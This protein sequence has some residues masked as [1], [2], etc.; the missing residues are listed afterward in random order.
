MEDGRLPEG[1][2]VGE[3]AREAIGGLAGVVGG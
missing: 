2:A 3:F 1:V